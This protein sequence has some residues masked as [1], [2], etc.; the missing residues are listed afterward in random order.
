MFLHLSHFEKI[1]W[2]LNVPLLFATLVI[3]IYLTTFSEWNIT[4]K[5][6]TIVGIQ[7]WAF[8]RYL[9]VKIQIYILI[10]LIG[11]NSWNLWQ[12][13]VV[14]F[15]QRCLNCAVPFKFSETVQ[16]ARMPRTPTSQKGYSKCWQL[17]GIPSRKRVIEKQLLLWQ[18]HLEH[19]KVCRKLNLS[20]RWKKLTEKL[21]GT[22]LRLQSINN[23]PA[24][25]MTTI[26]NKD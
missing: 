17:Q 12:L 18:D 9:S 21:N 5:M 11:S 25:L 2:S 24:P 23:K 10:W 8:H 1:N 3:L 13:K 22:G 14:N 20:F 16:S 26:D 15:R 7:T 19:S 4:L 6:W